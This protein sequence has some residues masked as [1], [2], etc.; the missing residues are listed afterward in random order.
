MYFLIL[1]KSGLSRCLRIKCHDACHNDVGKCYKEPVGTACQVEPASDFESG[2]VDYS[3]DVVEAEG[4]CEWKDLDGKCLKSSCSALHGASGNS[5]G[6][7]ICNCRGKRCD[8]TC[9][10]C[11]VKAK[12]EGKS[13]WTCPCGL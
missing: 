1:F 13:Q 6:E 11:E 5:K 4:Q 2:V 12:A 7:K 10:D 3:D 8:L 9:K